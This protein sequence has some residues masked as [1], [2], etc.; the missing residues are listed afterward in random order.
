MIESGN[1]FLWWWD[2]S[3]SETTIATQLPPTP[4]CKSSFRQLHCLWYS[5]KELRNEPYFLY[6]SNTTEKVTFWCSYRK[7]TNVVIHPSSVHPRHFV[8][9]PPTQLSLIIY[10]LLHRKRG[11]WLMMWKEVFSDGFL[12][13]YSHFI[14]LKIHFRLQTSY[15]AYCV[16]SMS[17]KEIYKPLRR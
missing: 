3:T 4:T 11:S 16:V 10:P 5:R 17:R 15:C 9:P 2:L 14:G 12:K 6:Q 13:L 8:T 1:H 7:L